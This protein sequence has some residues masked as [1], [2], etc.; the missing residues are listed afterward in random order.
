MSFETS[1]EILIGEIKQLE[2]QRQK[3][4]SQLNL[5]DNKL[6]EKNT[7]YTKLKKH[8]FF[9]NRIC[10]SCNE[11]LSREEFTD[12]IIYCKD[13]C[14]NDSSLEWNNRLSN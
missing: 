6:N 2:T 7:I 12:E 10:L 3:L 11:A 9:K 8:Y 13:C 14:D 1:N 4:I 5:L